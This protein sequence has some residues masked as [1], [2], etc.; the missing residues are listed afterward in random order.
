MIHPNGGGVHAWKMIEMMS[1]GHYRWAHSRNLSDACLRGFF[2]F[3]MLSF[4]LLC[5][6][7]EFY[8]KVGR[9]IYLFFDVVVDSLL[10]NTHT[11][12]KKK[13]IKLN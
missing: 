8:Q 11:H 4:F 7:C 1:K 10:A 2:F 5:F 3:L 13:K 6:C 9:F 12:K